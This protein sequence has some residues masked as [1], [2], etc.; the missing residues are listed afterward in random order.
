MTT[1]AE[2]I[3]LLNELEDHK[4]E[5]EK[6]LIDIRSEHEMALE[7]KRQEFRAKEVG[8]VE[9]GL[10]MRSL[11]QFMWQVPGITIAVTGGLWYGVSLWTS[12]SAKQFALVFLAIFDILMIVVLFRVRTVL[13]RHIARQKNSDFELQVA[14]VQ[15]NKASKW[16][17][18]VAWTKQDFLVVGIWSALLAFAGILSVLGALYPERVTSMKMIPS[19]TTQLAAKLDGNNLEPAIH[20][21][22]LPF[23]VSAQSAVSAA[24]AV[25]APRATR[26]TSSADVAAK[27]AKVAK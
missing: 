23:P 16:S 13:E 7:A 4:F 2:E 19:Q 15:A 9:A 10:H 6:K 26:A 20:S 17:W 11:N 27:T 12:D 8:Y 22:N 21:G 14:N 5:L 18:L 3:P 25:S 24:S 1:T